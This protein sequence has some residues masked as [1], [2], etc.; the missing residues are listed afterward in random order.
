[1]SGGTSQFV[2]TVQGYSGHRC[3]SAPATLCLL[4]EY[5]GDQ[6]Q[7]IFTAFDPVKGRGPE[8]LR[9]ATK[10][11][12]R[13]NWDVSPDGSQVAISFPA[14]ENRIR[15]FPLAGAPRDVVVNGWYGF[16]SG[17]D[18]SSDG[19]GFYVSSLSP[20]GVTLLYINL[21]GEAVALWE[22]K[23]GLHAWGLP[24][25]DGRRL[26]ILGYTM[27]SNIWLLENF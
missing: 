24:S 13:Y 4:G 14:G 23:G 21:N 26:A 16:D 19:K 18:W 10:P 2:L 20:T 27:D 12:F 3:A 11:G 5:S 6:S 17:P 1:V 15:V 7:L 22:Q 8:M 25:L 9:V